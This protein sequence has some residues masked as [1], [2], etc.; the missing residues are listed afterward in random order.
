M[1]LEELIGSVLMENKDLEIKQRLDRDNTIDWLKTV[2]GFANA[3]GGTMYIGATD[4]EHTLI[5]FDRTEADAERNYFNNQINEHVAPRPPYTISFIRYEIRGKERF[6]LKIEVENSP[7]KPVILNYKGVPSI[8]IRREG[9]TNGA[10]YEEIINMSIHSQS[11]S[12]DTIIS[13]QDYRSE[14]FQQLHSFYALHREGNELSEKALASLGFFNEEGKLANGAILFRD[15]YDDHKTDVQC[16]LFSGFT[17]GSERIV[18][19]NRFSGNITESIDYMVSY[20]IQRMNHTLIKKDESHIE[21]D[22]YPRR[23]LLEGIIN[24]VAHRDYFLDGTQIQVDMFRDRLEISSPGSF[25]HGNPLPKTYDLSSII[26]KRRNELICG[27]LV[28]CGVMEAAGTGFDKIVEEYKD[29]DS[30][31]KPFIFSA[32][33]HFTLVLPDLSYT[34][35]LKDSELPRLVFSPVPNGSRYDESILSYC[36]GIARTAS[37]IAGHLGISYSTYLKNKIIG[38]LVKNGYLTEEKVSKSSLYKTNPDMVRIQ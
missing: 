13:D 29:A 21:I 7:V 2:A 31:H 11:A 24:A 16:S 33:D 37:E 1:L 25:Y 23:A 20:V 28:H 38:N 9:F 15:H 26:S 5:G 22:A 18:S 34:E 14:D 6:I 27:V 4:K 17:K 3:N 10:T 36:Y 32:S 12:F 30:L 8:Y 35:G 19:V